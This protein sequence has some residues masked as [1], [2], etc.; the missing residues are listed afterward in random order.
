MMVVYYHEFQYVCCQSLA[1]SF[2]SLFPFLKKVRKSM[3]KKF[4][5]YTFLQQLK[6]IRP[7]TI[8]KPLENYL[9]F[10]RFSCQCQPAF[11]VASLKSPFPFL[12]EKRER[13]CV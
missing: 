13:R 2:Q 5:K 12:N 10:P 3:E 11:L 9:E 7:F 6:V 8:N 4:K 1:S